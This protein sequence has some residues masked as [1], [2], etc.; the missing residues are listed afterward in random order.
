MCLHFKGVCISR[1]R[2]PT[3]LWPDGS[4]KFVTV[5]RW[6]NLRTQRG[7]RYV[8][9]SSSTG[10]RTFMILV[11][12]GKKLNVVDTSLLEIQVPK[13]SSI[14]GAYGCVSLALCCATARQRAQASSGCTRVNA[15]RSAASRFTDNF[16]IRA[17]END[18]LWPAK[19][20]FWHFEYSKLNELFE[21][22]WC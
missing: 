15:V 10:L 18:A 13:C 21:R 7:F 22:T 2:H 14:N 20:P 6:S 12:T 11:W 9:Y 17:R 5:L 19:A 4:P 8:R 1:R 3:R 16:K